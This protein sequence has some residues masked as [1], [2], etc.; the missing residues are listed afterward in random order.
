[1]WGY[2]ADLTTGKCHFPV[3]SLYVRV[4]RCK[5]WKNSRKISSLIICEGISPNDSTRGFFAPFPH[6][7]WGYIGTWCTFQWKEQVPSL[8]VRVYRMQVTFRLQTSCSLIICEGISF[9]FTFIRYINEF[10]HYMWG[11]IATAKPSRARVRVPSLYVRV[12]RIRL[13][14]P[15][16]WASSL[17]ICEGISPE[18]L[19]QVGDI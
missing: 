16:W 15:R 1:M 14:R 17:I 18:D 12:Y 10:P 4:Y 13:R 7:M 3:P 5:K 8:Y 19:M 11:Y 6:Y 9:A 2:I